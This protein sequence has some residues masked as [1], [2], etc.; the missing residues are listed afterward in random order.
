MHGNPLVIIS[1][2]LPHDVA[3]PLQQPRRI[4]AW[5]ELETTINNISEAKNIVVC[6]DFN[7]ALHHNKEGEEDI[8]GQHISGKGL[9]FLRT[10]EE[11]QEPEFVDNREKLMSL[12]RSTNTVI[13][14]T[15]YQKHC[16]KHRIT[17]KAMTTQIGPP[18]TSE[19]YYEI[20][21]CLVKRHWRNS[22]LDI[23][24]DPY[25]NVNTDRYIIKIVIRQALKAKEEMHLEPTLKGNTIPEDNEDNSLLN[26]N[27][28]V[29]KALRR[30]Q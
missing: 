7:A 13:A 27:E 26:F 29:A 8:I 9:E 3:L 20:D 1:A 17:Y 2:Y 18:W 15:F 22:V 24:S 30:K 5:E 4:A 10:K 11:R 14:N 19:R 16:N 23:Q 28:Q 12:A 21:H 25:T 6:G